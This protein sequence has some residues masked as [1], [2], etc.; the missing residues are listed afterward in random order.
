[1]DNISFKSRII[2]TNTSSYHRAKMRVPAKNFVD[3]PWTPAQG[4]VANSVASSGFKDCCGGFITDGEKVVAGHFDPLN[5]INKTFSNIINFYNKQKNN[6]GKE[7]QALVIGGKAPCIAG[8][9]SY[10]QFDKLVDYFE[11]ENIPC[12]ILKGGMGERHVCY[13]SD[14]D[15]YVIG[16][17]VID[18]WDPH[19]R[20]TAEQAFKRVFNEVKIA[21]GDELIFQRTWF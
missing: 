4:K 2:L 12:S 21:P 18:R 6:L 15:E 10:R 8:E 3:Y 5:P 20:L 13:F 14:K 9:E 1:M 16:A 19:E 11:K 17:D 7:L